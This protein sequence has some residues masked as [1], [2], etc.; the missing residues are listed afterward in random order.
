M[1]EPLKNRMLRLVRQFVL[2]VAGYEAL[3]IGG[4]ALFMVGGMLVGYL[5]Y[6]DRPG[7]GWYGASNT[8][9]EL[10]MVGQWLR[11]N[12]WV[13]P[14]YGAVLFILMKGLS[15]VPRVPRALVRVVAS[16]LTAAIAIV[17]AL[18]TGWYFSLSLSVQWAAPLLSIAYGGWFLPR[19][20][21]AGQ[22]HAA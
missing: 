5:P 14:I 8:I 18:A 4:I 7:P 1:T 10:P 16:V 13:P 12:P 11:L 3:V 19:V 21:Y 6:T 9:H 15:I 20:L 22:P 17:W 2:A